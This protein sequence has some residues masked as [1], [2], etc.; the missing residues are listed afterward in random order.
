MPEPTDWEKEKIAFITDPR[1]PT[2]ENFCGI[3]KINYSTAMKRCASGKWLDLRN[4]HWNAVTEK[5]APMIQDFQASVLANDTASRL[6]EIRTMANTAFLALQP[7]QGDGLK[8]E[9]ASDAVA[10]YERLIKLERLLTDQSTENISISEARQ[11]VDD[12]LTVIEE[13]TRDYPELH[14]QIR[15]RLSGLQPVTVENPSEVRT[16][17]N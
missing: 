8:F 3:R 7:L 5:A 4:A 9:K 16:A 1:K 14:K 6:A 13:V 17:I 12:V 10:A 11:L 2:L 15:L